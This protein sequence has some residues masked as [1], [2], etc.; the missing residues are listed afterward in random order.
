MCNWQ[1]LQIPAHIGIQGNETAH[2]NYRD[3]IMICSEYSAKSVSISS[4]YNGIQGEK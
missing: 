2:K 3:A 4:Q 1:V